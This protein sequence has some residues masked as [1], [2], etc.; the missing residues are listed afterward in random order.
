MDSS[1]S[2]R[3]APIPKP[4]RARL[5][6]GVALAVIVVAGFVGLAVRRSIAERLAHQ[7]LAEHGVASN[8]HVRSLSMTGLSA[9]LRLGDPADPDLIVD[10][11]DVGYALSGPWNGRPFGVQTRSLRLIGAR[12][13][14][15]LT[16]G[17]VNFGALQR[18]VQE[19]AKQP[20]GGGAPPDLIVENGALLLVTPDGQLQL[21]GGGALRAGLLDRFDGEAEPFGLTFWGVRLQGRGGALHLAR[22]GARLVATVDLGPTTAGSGGDQLHAARLSLSAEMAYPARG[23]QSSGPARLSLEAKNVST[24]A[25]GGHA[26]GGTVSIDFDGAL[27]ASAARQDFSGRVLATGAFPSITQ[28]GVV[29]RG[30]SGRLDLVRLAMARDSA[31]MTANGDGLASLAASGAGVAGGGLS[32]LTSTARVEALR[33]SVTKSGGNAGGAV[34]GGLSGRGSLSLLTARRLARSVPV[35]SGEAAYA[36][37]IERGLRGFRFAAPQWRADFSDQGARLRFTSPMRLDTDSGAHLSLGV[38]PG[39]LTIGSGEASGAAAVSLEGGGAPRLNVQVANARASRS[40]FRADLA[41]RGSLDAMFARGAQFDLKGRLAGTGP[42]LRFDLAGCGPVSAQRL[43]FDPQSV[44][45]FSAALCPGDG[46]LIEV[47]S[48]GWTTRGRLVHVRGDAP[49]FA[50]NLREAGGA[51]EAVGGA[52]G[53]N[54]ATLVLDR[55]QIADAATPTRFHTVN[56]SGRAG[57]V[58]GV[59]SGAFTAS[60][61]AGHRIGKIVIRDDIASGVGRADIDSG[62]LVFA[63]G[64]LQPAELTPLANFARSADGSASF[65]GWFAWKSSGQPASGGELV[66]KDL[67]FKS[68]LGAVLGIDADLHFASLAPLVT[69]PDQKIA[70]AL[71]QAVTPVSGLSAQ[72]DLSANSITVDAA[73]GSIAQGRIRLEPII[74]PLTPG[75]SFKGVLVFDHVNIGEIIAATSLADSIKLEGVLDGRIPFEFGPSGLTINQGRLVAVGPGRLSISRKALTGGANRATAQVASGQA[76]FAQDLAYQAMENLAFEQLDAAMNSLPGERLGILFHIKGRHDPPQKQRAKIGL[77]DLLGG[78][79]LAKPID[80]PS[81]TRIDLTLDTSLNFGELVRGLGEAWR[82]SLA[83]GRSPPVQGQGS[84]VIQQTKGKERP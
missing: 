7:W 75:A 28:Q 52:K 65:T 71:V 80:L 83:D 11:L 82:D 62:G 16:D 20:P 30:V 32:A 9:G 40:G 63:P 84:S 39:G 35:L 29:A 69:A 23:G 6:V 79:A 17:R 48:A 5:V 43:A 68:P 77:N 3:P 37:A 24:I 12:L 64:G 41:A 51:F 78:R 76:G 54:T 61:R 25:G 1:G 60:T 8:L 58:A 38:P 49:S 47:G 36:A 19:V 26:D 57:L 45:E 13:R 21:R 14:L 10:R 55:G 46:P 31:A 81:D 44:S 50:A 18:L 74:A 59:W 4:R 66:A 72:F 22:D 27:H 2:E 33:V 73:S 56:A 67:K 42:R 34:A 70:V 15:R 53:L